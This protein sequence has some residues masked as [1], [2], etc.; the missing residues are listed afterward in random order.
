MTVRSL[1][2]GLWA[3]DVFPANRGL[4]SEVDTQKAVISGTQRSLAWVSEQVM[5]TLQMGG[6]ESSEDTQRAVISSTVRSLGVGLW[7]G[8]VHPAI[9]RPV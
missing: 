1:G 8:D 5:C 6:L 7:T 3:G 2:V 9:G 4:R